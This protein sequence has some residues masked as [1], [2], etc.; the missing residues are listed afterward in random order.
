VDPREH[1]LLAVT[2]AHRLATALER[3]ATARADTVDGRLVA[4]VLALARHRT[5]IDRLDEAVAETRDRLSRPGHT[6]GDVIQATVEWTDLLYPVLRDGHEVPRALVQLLA[7]GPAADGLEQQ[8]HQQQRTD[9]VGRAAHRLGTA[10]AGRVDLTEAE[11]WWALAAAAG[12]A[13]AARARAGVRTVTPDHPTPPRRREPVDLSRPYRDPRVA[14][15]LNASG[16]SAGYLYLGRRLRAAIALAATAAVLLFAAANSA[17]H[18]PGLWFTVAALGVAGMAYDAWR[19]ARPPYQPRTVGVPV[20][21]RL[22]VAG[23]LAIVV[24]AAGF[25]LYRAAAQRALD[26][27][28]AA[29]AAGDCAAAIDRY[30]AVSA[31]F[32]LTLSPVVRAAQREVGECATLVLAE[33]DL[34]EGDHDG[35][36]AGFDGYL[37]RYPEGAHVERA[38]GGRAEAYLQRAGVFAQTVAA[39]VTSGEAPG[40]LL[41]RALEDYAVV[42]RQ[43]PGSRQAQ[44]VPQALAELYEA[45]DPEPGCAA[46]PVLDAFTRMAGLEPAPPVAARAAEALP[47]ALFRCGTDQYDDEA[48][49]DAIDSLE[50]LIDTYPDHPRAAAAADTLIAADVAATRQGETGELDQ[51]LEVGTTARGRAVVE[52]VNDSPETLEILVSGPSPETATVEACAGCQVRSSLPLFGTGTCG[53]GDVPVTTLRLAPGRY[54]V[55]VRARSGGGVTPYSGSWRLRSGTAYSSCF[56]VSE[57]FLPGP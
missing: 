37:A 7:S 28:R 40:N 4:Q 9:A 3:G 10:A 49:D 54:E 5:A 32:E 36:V 39:D 17:S 19:L 53:V 38:R 55:V 12:H 6:S 22:V 20:P 52:I 29:H 46:V 21:W 47:E 1:L 56:Y 13:G 51:P 30:H 31:R 2:I 23:A 18:S 27:A 8:A 15:L 11:A 24:V 50:R 48:Y 43:H 57:S 35:A 26:G 41:D 25:G 45:T 44:A 16:L 33:T 34:S 14:A 42:V